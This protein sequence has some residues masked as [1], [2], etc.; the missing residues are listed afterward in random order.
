[1]NKS[2][3]DA[4]GRFAAGSH[5]NA[6]GRPKKAA[7]LFTKDQVLEDI[8]GILEEPVTVVWK[9]RKQQI[10]TIVGV[11]RQLCQKALSGDFRAIEL[12]VKLRTQLTEERTKTIAALQETVISLRRSYA[13]KE[14]P[15]PVRAL[16]VEAELRL[17][18]AEEYP[19]HPQS[20]SEEDQ[21]II[22]QAMVEA[23]TRRH[24]QAMADDEEEHG[25]Y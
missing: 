6:R 1:M 3:R 21:E 7:R 11:Y 17:A 22:M 8:L 16:L 15:D 25:I 13:G 18:R 20:R 24:E 9:G 10:P 5:G 19:A 2:E 14:M 4:N 23:A 12:V